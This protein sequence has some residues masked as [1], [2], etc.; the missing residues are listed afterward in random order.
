MLR[1]RSLRLR[2]CITEAIVEKK[3]E[4][5]V[6]HQEEVRVNLRM[7]I[8]GA[9]RENRFD[10]AIKATEML[11]KMDG[12]ANFQEHPPEERPNNGTNI[13]FGVSPA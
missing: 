2:G 10:D 1:L 7:I 9:I 6:D 11:G 4:V 3:A 8:E 5:V 12:C 13:N